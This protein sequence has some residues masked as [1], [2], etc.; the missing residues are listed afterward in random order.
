MLK[1]VK[2]N[3]K[4]ISFLL[5]KRLCGEIEKRERVCL[6]VYVCERQRERKKE[7]VITFILYRSP[8]GVKIFNPPPSVC[9]RERKRE[10]E[11]VFVCVC[12]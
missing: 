2:I 11:S 1:R 4:V 7:R 3:K 10:R 8:C 6:F 12:L 9:V 5:Y